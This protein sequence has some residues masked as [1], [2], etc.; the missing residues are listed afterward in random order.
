MTY[1]TRFRP[2][3]VWLTVLAV[4]ATLWLWSSDASAG[5]AQVWTISSMSGRVNIVRS[6]TAPVALT[7]GDELRS[8]DTIETSANSSATL[9]RDG[10]SILIAPNSSMALPK[11]NDS[12]YSTLVLQKLGTL[13]FKVEKQQ[14]Q[15][16]EVK[17][18][19][20][21][22]VVK[23][24]T[25]AIN[26]SSAG[27]SVHVIEGAVQVN[28]LVGKVALVRPG[29]TAIVSADPGATLS[30]KG[31]T[32]KAPAQRSDATPDL[33]ADAPLRLA[34]LPGESDSISGKAKSKKSTDSGESFTIDQTVGSLDI[35]IGTATNGLMQT[36]GPS[37]GSE[38]A[39]NHKDGKQEKSSFAAT[40]N[41]LDGSKSKATKEKNTVAV[42]GDS[43]ATP[44]ANVSNGSPAA[45]GNPVA[46]PAVGNQ[47]AAPAVGNPVAAPAVGNPGGAPAVGNPFGGPV[48]AGQSGSLPA[49]ASAIAQAN[50]ALGA[51]NKPEKLVK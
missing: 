42:P 19:Y 9:V 17:T 50:A 49:T 20:L 12:G 6:G 5:S 38:S 7:T 27:T 1:C 43:G 22:A 51:K 4:V 37:L 36:A 24:T 45:G 46:A 25:F 41:T 32:P 14:Q 34:E 31:D 29:Q 48:A 40:E 44:A 33:D 8:G 11:T 13:L 18:P 35:D 15:H 23:G 16:F 26:V 47:V 30:I 21:A 10:E 28:D 3:T 39:K 2:Q